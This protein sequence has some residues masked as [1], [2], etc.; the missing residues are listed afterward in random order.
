M[1][2]S[3]DAAVVVPALY[4]PIMF[5]PRRRPPLN[6]SIPPI[7]ES[8]SNESIMSHASRRSSDKV[9]QSP[10]CVVIENRSALEQL[11]R[12]QKTS[13]TSI[14]R[15]PSTKKTASQKKEPKTARSE[16]PRSPLMTVARTVKSKFSKLTRMGRHDQDV[17]MKG[18]QSFSGIRQPKAALPKRVDQNANRVIKSSSMEVP[19]TSQEQPSTSRHMVVIP[20]NPKRLEDFSEEASLAEQG[21][22]EEAAAVDDTTE[23]RL[24]LTNIPLQ[25]HNDHQALSV[26]LD[27]DVLVVTKPLEPSDQS[28]KTPTV[29]PTQ[30]KPST[31]RVTFTEQQVIHI[32]AVEA[33]S[34]PMSSELEHAKSVDSN[35]KP[36]EEQ[37][38]TT[39]TPVGSRK[40]HTFTLGEKI[41][42]TSSELK[43][44]VPSVEP[45]NVGSVERELSPPPRYLMSVKTPESARKHRTFVVTHSDPKA[46]PAVENSAVAKKTKR[47]K[48]IKQR[49]MPESTASP[50]CY[51]LKVKTP[52]ALRRHH[53]FT[54]RERPRS[55]DVPYIEE[56]EVTEPIATIGPTAEKLRMQ[57]KIEDVG[58]TKEDEKP[59]PEKFTMS[60]KTPLTMK[61]FKTFIVEEK[62][63][64]EVVRT[65]M[66]VDALGPSKV[67]PQEE[68]VKAV[69]S[70]STK[71]NTVKGERK[72]IE[73]SE[74]LPS[75]VTATPSA[76]RKSQ[77]AIIDQKNE[78]DPQGNPDGIS[79]LSR[80]EELSE[81]GPP[82][83]T[84]EM[85]VLTTMTPLP[86][87]KASADSCL[88]RIAREK[89]RSSSR[90][91]EKLSLF[92]M[93]GRFPRSHPPS[94]EGKR[95]T[96]YAVVQPRQGEAD[97]ATSKK[98][99]SQSDRAEFVERRN[100][101][102]SGEMT[103]P[104]EE[105][106]MDTHLTPTEE[107]HDDTLIIRPIRRPP[108]VTSPIAEEPEVSVAESP[109]IE[110]K[111]VRMD[112]QLES[113]TSSDPPV[114][115]P[116]S[117]PRESFKPVTTSK[118]TSPL[119]RR[120]ST[121]EACVATRE[122]KK[123]VRLSF[124]SKSEDRKE[125]KM[126]ER[127]R[128]KKEKREEKE[129]TPRS[130]KMPIAAS[131]LR[132]LRSAGKMLTPAFFRKAADSK[133][134]K[135]T[136]AS[137]APSPMPATKPRMQLPF[138]NGQKAPLAEFESSVVE[139]SPAVENNPIT[140]EKWNNSPRGR[141]RHSA[142]INGFTEPI[143]EE[144]D[145]NGNAICS[146]STTAPLSSRVECVM[147]PTIARHEPAPGLID[148][149]ILDQPMLV[150]DTFSH[151]ES[152]DCL[153]AVRRMEF[154]AEKATLISIDRSLAEDSDTMR[155]ATVF[156]TPSATYRRALEDGLNEVDDIR[157]QLEKLQ[158]LVAQEM[159]S[160]E[161]E[162]LVRENEALRRELLAKDELISTLRQQIA[163]QHC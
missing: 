86:Q 113:S 85:Y 121:E 19:P 82:L 51:I 96:K 101:V 6:R 114:F 87:R 142:H 54:I 7:P 43:A 58:K 52:E 46:K 55:P 110:E 148:D 88:E 26:T 91:P 94:V 17:S 162:K 20:Q 126:E 76:M 48:I 145:G 60:V 38:N 45:Q 134:P 68:E 128:L 80:L 141:R 111:A 5:A 135:P 95:P 44:V 97:F 138:R 83:K 8:K 118:S 1:R 56:G 132:S 137:H 25:H 65:S 40:H 35:P 29:S 79:S 63:K 14:P 124:R 140:F 108:E 123:R 103:S 151:S 36:P 74:K 15:P 163:T 136:K 47:V 143:V 104:E 93:G 33:K 159:H 71:E 117:P 23:T 64:E 11:Q 21:K 67:G 37:V 13:G 30:P 72:E 149:E 107:T 98:D 34:S 41:P 61:K 115:R 129:R 127:E 150:G 102:S 112:V 139:D 122:E 106:P 16:T 92:I 12:L 89:T 57:K 160:T 39:K 153:S 81:V 78:E 120:G 90:S 49:S 24:L 32:S 100:S 2:R 157:S 62:K 22:T 131:I 105:I 77:T 161:M 28:E 147:S 27:E 50:E 155:A 75:A 133:I 109:F 154:E 70:V 18:S 10:D 125:K 158:L 119:R 116:P 9:E 69:L 4:G 152:N 53:T 99:H 59:P 66:S 84:S 146:A 3:L 130:P 73:K 42:D 144:S 31:E 156:A